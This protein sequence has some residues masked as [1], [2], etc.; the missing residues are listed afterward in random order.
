MNLGAGNLGDL[1]GNGFGD[2]MQGD[3]KRIQGYCSSLME[4]REAGTAHPTH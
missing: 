1:M 3:G 4:E 2:K